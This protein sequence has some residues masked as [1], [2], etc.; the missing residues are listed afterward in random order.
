VCL[1]DVFEMSPSDLAAEV[2]NQY[3]GSN[4]DGELT[5]DETLA[6]FNDLIKDEDLDYTDKDFD[7]FIW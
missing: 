4:A 2:M 3:G 7:E 6:F 5:Y 1:D